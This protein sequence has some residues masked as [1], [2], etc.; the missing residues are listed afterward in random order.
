MERENRHSHRHRH[1][2][3][4]R[5]TMENSSAMKKAI[6]SPASGLPESGLNSISSVSNTSRMVSTSPLPSSLLRPVP[7]LLLP[8]LSPTPSRFSVAMSS[9]KDPL[10]T[11]AGYCLAKLRRPRI[12]ARRSSSNVAD[13]K[14]P[15]RVSMVAVA[16]WRGG[17]LSIVGRGLWIMYYVLWIVYRDCLWSCPE[18]RS[19]VIS[20]PSCQSEYPSGSGPILVVLSLLSLLTLVLKPNKVSGIWNLERIRSS[21][22]ALTSAHASSSTETPATKSFFFHPHRPQPAAGQ[23]HLMSAISSSP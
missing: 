6:S 16:V 18:A 5:H 9:R 4:H 13:C 21:S 23:S 20:L 2:H 1:R 11:E 10:A 14:R 8:L 12:A 15:H 22:S 3:R 19:V 7:F 17:V